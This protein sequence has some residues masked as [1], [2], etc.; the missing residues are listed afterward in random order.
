MAETTPD[1]SETYTANEKLSLTDKFDTFAKSKWLSEKGIQITKEE[2]QKLFDNSGKL[3][4]AFLR[5]VNTK[6]ENI[7]RAELW[8]DLAIKSKAME[9]VSV[10]E[11]FA[12]KVKIPEWE[13]M[14]KLKSFASTFGITV[15]DPINWKISLYNSDGK[16][17]NP[18]VGLVTPHKNA[19]DEAFATFQTQNPNLAQK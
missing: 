15:W 13:A 16:K 9:W 17:I 5:T 14:G 7:I 19:Q 2:I 18:P 1:I 3:T 8:A 6:I 11:N 10:R 12:E 4:Q